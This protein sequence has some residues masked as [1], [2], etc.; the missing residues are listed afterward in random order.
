MSHALSAIIN[1]LG[2]L[3]RYAYTEIVCCKRF[4]L[5]ILW[6]ID[7]MLT[8]KGSHHERCP[9]HKNQAIAMSTFFP[10]TLL[11]SMNPLPTIVVAA[12]AALTRNVC[13]S[14]SL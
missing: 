11:H 5:R 6:K 12:N 4:E 13:I 9:D 3:S 10:F 8:G 1:S 7:S 2:R 14:A